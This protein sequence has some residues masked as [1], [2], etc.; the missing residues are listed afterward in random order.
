MTDTDKPHSPSPIP[1]TPLTFQ[2]LIDLRETYYGTADPT[3]I[4][5]ASAIDHY[6]LSVVKTLPQA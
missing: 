2:D 3:S 5:I 6:I 1:S 4:A